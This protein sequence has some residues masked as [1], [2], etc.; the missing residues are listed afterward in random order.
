[1]PLGVPLGIL[2]SDR[3]LPRAFDDSIAAARLNRRLTKLPESAFSLSEAFASQ[4]C[5]PQLH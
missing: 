4:A 3:H 2:D 5:G 1:M